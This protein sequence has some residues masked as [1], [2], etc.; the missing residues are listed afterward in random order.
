MR[1]LGG[2]AFILLIMAKSQQ[3]RPD[4]LLNK[5]IGKQVLK[6]RL[7]DEDDNRKLQPFA[8]VKL[9]RTNK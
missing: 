9:P 4:S 8:R 5:P 1:T 3:I 7:M 2:T 6:A